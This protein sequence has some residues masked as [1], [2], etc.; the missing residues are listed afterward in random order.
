MEKAKTERLSGIATIERTG[1]S[2]VGCM[3]WETPYVIFR[4]YEDEHTDKYVTVRWQSENIEQIL[5]DQ[6]KIRWSMLEHSAGDLRRH[7]N[8]HDLPIWFDFEVLVRP[9][10]ESSIDR[11][12][13]QVWRMKNL[14]YR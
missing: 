12:D 2:C 9:V 4:V 8:E 6:D 11:Q 3:S 5:D 1:S 13:Y 7:P 10:K 14:K